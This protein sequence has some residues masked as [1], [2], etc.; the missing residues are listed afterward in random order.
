MLLL[1]FLL[2]TAVTPPASGTLQEQFD[3]A[4]KA[5]AADD[6]AKALPLFAAL[7]TRAEL[8]PG[9]LP[10]SAIAVRKG[11]C[12]VDDG[13]T[14]EGESAI[15]EGLPT[16]IKAG[17]P[18]A[19][20]V[21]K[22]RE[23]LANVAY[24]HSSYEEAARLYKLALKPLVGEERI[25]LLAELAR[26][27]TFDSGPEALAASQEAISLLE[28]ERTPNKKSL[29]AMH[30]LHARTLLNQGQND[31][32]YAE[33]KKA[34]SLSG[35]LDLRVSLS[36]V[37]LRSDLAMAAM[38]TRRTDEART[39][40]AYTGA[41]R[42]SNSPFASAQDMPLPPCGS[43]T[44]LTPDDIAVVEFGISSDGHVISAHTVYTLG[45]NLAAQA[46]D[47]AVRQWYWLPAKVA[48]IPVFFRTLSR[49]EL[50]CT[51]DA[52]SGPGLWAPLT[53]RF[54]EWGSQ[55]LDY[56]S[57]QVRME[58]AKLDDLRRIADGS[59]PGDDP[60]QQIVAI[61]VLNM[62]D[63]AAS[64]EARA[65][66]L[67]KSLELAK[68]AQVPTSVLNFLKLQEFIPR[69][70]ASETEKNKAIQQAATALLGEP[71]IQADALAVDTLK[72]F[73]A[74]KTK[75]K[76]Q[77]INDSLLQVANDKRLGDVHPLR[78]MA[79]LLLAN[80]SAAAGD[81][82]AAQANFARTG[83]SEAQCALLDLPPAMRST[84]VSSSD[85]PISAQQMGFEG[86][87][88]I[89]YDIAADGKTSDV[90]AVAAYPA[91]VFEEAAIKIGEGL[92]YQGSYRPGNGTACSTEKSTINF[93]LN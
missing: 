84:N 83:L 10:A 43:E 59:A 88:K 89:E 24:Q 47:E 41:G 22:A 90:R 87:A 9:S 50:R 66:R 79:W 5:A 60:L 71:S 2:A 64:D 67:A 11:I 86:W 3:A 4:S 20:D 91:F 15:V 58:S 92:R 55:Y 29:V 56:T 46:F 69:R 16:L 26:A 13:K 37:A 57:A 12:L 70:G 33:L 18:F 35:G 48:S 25:S 51:S 53:N 6:C 78:Q 62:I 77:A 44:G 8:K 14:D 73:L 42:I 28:V 63:V 75:P 40:L 49:I 30:V 39:Y 19:I 82:N 76:D 68:T 21:S 17:A 72:L 93:L 27:T 36:D 1:P 34:L 74:R 65:R 23:A 38:L 61:G 80:R 7:E 81:L 52:A 45:G 85:Y 32:A 54:S 31:L